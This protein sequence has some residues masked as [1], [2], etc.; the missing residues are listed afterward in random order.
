MCTL[1]SGFRLLTNRTLCPAVAVSP[2]RPSREAAAAAAAMPWCPIPSEARA[3]GIP[4]MDKPG[5][6]EF[7]CVVKNVK[8]EH[9][10]RQRK[11]KLYKSDNGWCFYLLA[12]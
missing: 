9:K 7:N 6:Q 12:E 4:G 3:L 1:T 5:T 8:E 11:P 2:V 10:H